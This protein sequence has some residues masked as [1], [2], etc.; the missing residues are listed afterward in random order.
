MIFSVHQIQ[1]F[2]SSDT[3]KNLTERVNAQR[4]SA[5]QSRARLARYFVGLGGV[6]VARGS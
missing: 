6:G 3:G 1:F 4:A 2:L 5:E